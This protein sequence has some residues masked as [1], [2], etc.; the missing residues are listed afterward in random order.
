[1][2]YDNDLR[3]RSI[4]ALDHVINKSDVLEIEK[5]FAKPVW[6]KVLKVSKHF[7]N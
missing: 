6:R 2:V 5:R 7:A 3:N 1:M 4:V